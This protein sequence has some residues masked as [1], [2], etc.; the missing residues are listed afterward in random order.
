MLRRILFWLIWIALLYCFVALIVLAVLQYRHYPDPG[1]DDWE[2]LAMLS[3]IFGLPWAGM[4]Y[5]VVETRKRR[6][7]DY[8]DQTPY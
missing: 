6:S 4:T 2:R 1:Y 3:L 7:S 8:Q 5:F